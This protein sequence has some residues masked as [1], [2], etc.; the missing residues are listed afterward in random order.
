MRRDV[1]IAVGLF[2]AG[3]LGAC[4]SDSDTDIAVAG[5]EPTVQDSAPEPEETVP[6]PPS[7]EP[8]PE[9]TPSSFRLTAD[10]LVSGLP[11]NRQ[12][13][14]IQGYKFKESD[15][16]VGDADEGPEWSN[17]APLTK[18]QKKQMRFGNV[19]SVRP[20]NCVLNAGF[21]GYGWPVKLSNSDVMKAVAFSA[22]D[23]D[24][25]FY[26]KDKVRRWETVAYVLPP[27]EAQLWADDI[28][29]MTYKCRKY[30]YRDS[31]GNLERVNLRRLYPKG[32]SI[33]MSGSAYVLIADPD[34]GGNPVFF[35]SMWEPL[36]D[37]LYITYV[38]LY[39]GDESVIGRAS[40]VYNVLADNL[41]D[42]AGVE[43]E[44][45]DLNG[46]T[47]FTPNPELFVGPS[48][49]VKP[50]SVT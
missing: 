46:L 14:K 42:E 43:R 2:V 24:N 44:P 11:S 39:T 4:A 22:R 23:N 31:E 28:A 16:W 20:E 33:F 25:P 13:S 38:T 9:P 36:G 48:V 29:N 45:V 17:S 19:A 37:T 6:E 21:H 12:M 27:G 15:D 47:P 41:A 32:E 18:K 30:S 5:A 26:G 10:Q 40:D 1:L 50:G 34:T 35:A 3:A 8:T 7:P 49:G